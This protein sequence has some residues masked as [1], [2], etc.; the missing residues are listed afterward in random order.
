M[1]NDIGNCGRIA[2]NLCIALGSMVILAMLIL[3][4]QENW[5]IFPSTYVILDFFH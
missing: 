4:I 5:Y 1:K 3:S 2:L